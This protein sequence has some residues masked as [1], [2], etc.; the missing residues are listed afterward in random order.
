MAINKKSPPFVAAGVLSMLLGVQSKHGP[1]RIGTM[2]TMMPG[3]G[4]HCHKPKV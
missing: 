2:V 1:S 4:A 3:D